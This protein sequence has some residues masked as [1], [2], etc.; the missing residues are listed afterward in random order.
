MINKSNFIILFIL[1]AFCFSQ[2]QE[3]VLK[4]GT[5]FTGTVISESDTDLVVQTNFGA[6]TIKKSDLV[7]KEFNIKMVSG[8]VFRGTKQKDTETDIHLLTNI[9]LLKISKDNIASI[10][11]IG[12]R[13]TNRYSSNYN[14]NKNKSF[15]IGEE[16]LID[17]FFDPTAYTLPKSTFYISGLSFGFG[18]TDKMQVTTKWI[19][20]LW[21]DFNLRVKNQLF[22]VGNW[23][24]QQAL[25]IG[26][27][28]HTR[29][30]KPAS[31]N[32]N[33]DDDDYDNNDHYDDEYDDE[34]NMI[35][36]FGAYTYSTAR[37]G[38]NGRTSHTFGGNFK[39][40]FYDNPLNY[41]RVY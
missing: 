24:Q 31:Y 25:S 10:E 29:W 16:Q 14:I 3:Y 13:T 11:E 40:T 30:S 8:E 35:E 28:Y 32:N 19:N 26:A 33:D 2:N 12:Q 39:H 9:G 41:Y 23:E 15:S 7:L 36:V 22:L 34:T 20:Y 18:V 6:V 37:E 27:H 4:D 17:L 38:L 5:K 21:G 1:F